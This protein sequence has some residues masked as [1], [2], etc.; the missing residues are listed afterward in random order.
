MSEKQKEI[1]SKYFV[2]VHRHVFVCD[3]KYG[4]AEHGSQAV[5]QAI[6]NELD[7]LGIRSQVKTN[8]M[9]CTLGHYICTN[10]VN[11]VVYPDGVWYNVT[12]ADIPE[13]VETHL[14][15]GQIVQRLNYHKI[16]T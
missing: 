16:I 1:L 7:R 3:D 8:K 11:V 6:R 2:P 4:C 9:N 13:I 5:L 14:K 10:G 15:N 12:L